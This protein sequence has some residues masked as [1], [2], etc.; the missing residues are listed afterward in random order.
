MEE[1][2]G[3]TTR[4]NIYANLLGQIGDPDAKRK[5]GVIADEEWAEQKARS[6]AYTV[7]L[8][9]LDA[10]EDV[11]DDAFAAILADMQ[12]IVAEPTQE[13]INAANI[14]YLLMMGGD[15]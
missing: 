1:T 11:D 15:E 2:D 7:A 5:A 4:A 6:L 3:L 10:G 9:R 12:G 14:D 13:E 8:E